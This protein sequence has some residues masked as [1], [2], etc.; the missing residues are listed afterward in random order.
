[1]D[2]IVEHIGLAARNTITLAG[3]YTRVLAAETLFVSDGTPP[4]FFLGLPGGLVIEIYTASESNDATGHNGLAGWRHLALQVS[5]I[6]LI[7]TELEARGVVFKENVKPAGGGGRV[8]FF[9]DPEGNLL[10]LVERPDGSL[11]RRAKS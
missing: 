4:A 11:F 8:L 6:E 3:W 1:M 7:R 9:S 2:F 10:H 5:S